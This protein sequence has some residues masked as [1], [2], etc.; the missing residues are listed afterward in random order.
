M[1][2]YLPVIVTAECGSLTRAAQTLGYTQPSLGYIIS[3]LEEELGAKIFFRSQRGMTLT[4]VG[5]K[6]LQT[7]RKIEALEQELQEQA[8]VGQG[9]LLRVGI[10]PSVAAQWLP[11]ILVDLRREF[12]DTTIKLEHQIYYLDGEIGVKEHRLDCAFFTGK[13]P[14]G[15]DRVVLYEDPYYLIVN[16]NSDLADLEEVSLEDVV[17]KYQFIPTHESFDSESAIW[18][19]YHAFEKKNVVDVQ[20]QENRMAVAMVEADLGITI[21]PGLD[22]MD[23]G[24]PRNVKAIPFREGLSRTISLLCP[25]ALEKSPL[26]AAFLRFTQKRVEAWKAEKNL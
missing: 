16:S 13:C 8:Q 14:P 17:G 12:P 9:G 15:L 1:G 3:N 11:G 2:K 24:A 5:A 4:D 20:P 19:V 22:A 21:L 25:K 6:M 18:E 26:I 10:F 7:M 23:L